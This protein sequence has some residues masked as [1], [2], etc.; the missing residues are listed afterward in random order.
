MLSGLNASIPPE[1]FD[2]A[3]EQLNELS[4]MPWHSA[5]EHEYGLT[6]KRLR[7]ARPLWYSMFSGPSDLRKL[8]RHLQCEASYVQLYSQL[9]E[10]AHGVSSLDIHRQ[11]KHRVEFA[12]LRNATRCMSLGMIATGFLLQ[13]AYEKCSWGTPPVERSTI[14]YFH[15]TRVRRRMP[16][17][18]WVPVWK[19]MI[20]PQEPS[21]SE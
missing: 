19:C 13:A 8:A 18:E 3:R 20:P 7:K 21:P 1:M 14:E 10:R 12:K 11:E 15:M 2:L 16:S 4:E 9:S 6:Q 5:M 17:G